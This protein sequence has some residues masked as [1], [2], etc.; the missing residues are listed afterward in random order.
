MQIS[1]AG[2]ADEQEW[3]EYVVAQAQAA[4]YQLFA[5]GR[6][7]HL[8]YGHKPIYWIARESE[9]IVGVLPG[10]LMNTPFKGGEYCSLP[11]CDMGGALANNADIKSVLESHFKEF[12]LKSSKGEYSLREGTNSVYSD[13]ELL[14]IKNIAPKLAP[15]VRMLLS[16][17]D[18]SEALLKGFKSKLRSQIRK[19]E[20][21]GLHYKIE[22]GPAALQDFYEVFALNMKNLGSPVHGK[23]WFQSLA[24]FYGDR[25]VLSVVYL[26]DI[27]VGGGIVLIGGKNACIPWAS[28]VPKYN[29]LS[30]NMLLY[31][32]LLK[33]VC[34]RG[35]SLFDFGRSSFDEGTFKFKAQWGAQPAPLIWR[36]QNSDANTVLPPSTKS[37]YRPLIEN[38]W[39]RLP[40]PVAN[41]VGPLLRKHISL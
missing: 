3:D 33:E 40:L 39:R 1:Q 21:N 38:A 32:S 15:K 18:S 7:C 17:P 4:P 20:K 5:W 13:D 11:F 25:L 12:A 37:K 10:V 35:C 24:H 26:D 41:F 31:W 6:A 27:P 9:Q 8:A 36:D 30:P 23:K 2:L 28:T 19:A 29:S 14:E 22:S 34:D 16:L